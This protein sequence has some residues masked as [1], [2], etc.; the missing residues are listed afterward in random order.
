MSDDRPHAIG[1]VRLDLVIP[2]VN[3][4]ELAEKHGYRM[5]FTVKTDTGPAI[6]ALALAHQAVEHSAKAVVVP[7]FEHAESVRHLATDIGAL[8]T[9]MQLYPPGYRWPTDDNLR[10]QAR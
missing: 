2:D 7:G 1:L 3:L 9:P 8:I 4:Y 10:E 6:T 5:V